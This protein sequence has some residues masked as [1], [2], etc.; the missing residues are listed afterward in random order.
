MLKIS[1]IPVF[2]YKEYTGIRYLDE[3]QIV[4]IAGHPIP[5]WPDASYLKRPVIRLYIETSGAFQKKYFFKPFCTCVGD[6][7]TYD[8][9]L[10]YE[11][12]NLSI[13]ILFCLPE[14]IGP[15]IIIDSWW[16]SK[17]LASCSK[18]KYEKGRPH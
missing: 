8:D 1:R 10:K 2:C 9:N 15:M 18:N 4:F 12:I 17:F 6:S 3:F 7:N 11:F 13:Q 5:I 16:Q 14:P